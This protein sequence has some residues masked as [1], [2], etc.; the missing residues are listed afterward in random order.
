[1]G[2]ETLDLMEDLSDRFGFTRDV[3]NAYR[4]I[5][6][7]LDYDRNYVLF[8]QVFYGMDLVYEIN[9]MTVDDNRYPVEEPVVIEKIEI[10]EFNG[11]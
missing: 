3:I 6:G 10:V 9:G 1:M 8:G 5:G 2:D 7:V 4:H 11:R